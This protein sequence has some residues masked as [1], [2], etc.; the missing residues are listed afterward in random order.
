MQGLMGVRCPASRWALGLGIGRLCRMASLSVVIRSSSAVQLH[1]PA[2]LSRGSRSMCELL[3]LPTRFNSIL[4][5]FPAACHP[6]ALR[7]SLGPHHR[8]DGWGAAPRP[9]TCPHTGGRRA[10]GAESRPQRRCQ[11]QQARPRR[12]Q[13]GAEPCCG[14]RLAARA[15]RTRAGCCQGA[16]F[17]AR[18]AAAR[19]APTPDR[20][21]APDQAPSAPRLPQAAAGCPA[22]TVPQSDACPCARGGSARPPCQHAAASILAATQLLAALPE[23][24]PRWGYG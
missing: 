6:W 19:C 16:P 23:L 2:A 14:T 18:A 3:S 15:Q 22:P 17:V 5:P 11:A 7:Q 9:R 13:G 12:C 8:A 10:T 20:C 4:V 21:P 24:Q 1:R